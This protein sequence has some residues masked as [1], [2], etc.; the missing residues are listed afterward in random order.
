MSTPYDRARARQD[1][2]EQPF[3]DAREAMTQQEADLQ[4]QA[5][6]YGEEHPH[7]NEEERTARLE[8]QAAERLAD[9]GDEVREEREEGTRRDPGNP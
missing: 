6:G 5:E 9:V 7:E 2:G 3:K 8:E 1:A 4:A